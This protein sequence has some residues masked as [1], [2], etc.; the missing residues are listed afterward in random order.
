M[1]PSV[2]TALAV[3][4]LSAVAIDKGFGPGFIDDAI[5]YPAVIY[6]AWV[7]GAVARLRSAATGG[8]RVW[9]MNV[10]SHGS[11]SAVVL[12]LLRTVARFELPVGE[13]TTTGHYP[14]FAVPVACTVAQVVWELM[15][16]RITNRAPEMNV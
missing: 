12:V 2:L 10:M 6:A 4:F 5:A 8:P 9:V 11:V 15:G 3:G 1:L 14:Y 13:F 7:A 16:R